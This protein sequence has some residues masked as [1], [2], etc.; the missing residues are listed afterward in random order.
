MIS[1]S[2]YSAERDRQ[3]SSKEIIHYRISMCVTVTKRTYFIYG[4]TFK[5]LAQENFLT[6][7]KRDFPGKNRNFTP[8]RRKKTSFMGS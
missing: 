3:S 4:R 6:R 8:L 1:R 2:L 7:E 5:T